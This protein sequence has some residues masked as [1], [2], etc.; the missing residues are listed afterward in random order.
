MNEQP[1]P[2]QIIRYFCGLAFWILLPFPPQ[3]SSLSKLGILKAIKMT[4]LLYLGESHRLAS[5]HEGSPSLPPVLCEIKTFLSFTVLLKG[6]T[7]SCVHLNL[8]SGFLEVEKFPTLFAIQIAH[9]P[10]LKNWVF[11][12]HSWKDYLVGWA[13][14]SNCFSS[15]LGGLAAKL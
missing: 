7:F 9:G 13:A 3:C 10:L 6:T 11:A 12:S 15:F 14:V 8:Y 2:T 5:H 4:S 1:W